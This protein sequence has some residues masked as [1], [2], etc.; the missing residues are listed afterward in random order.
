MVVEIYPAWHGTTN[1][2][3][4]CI[5]AHGFKYEKYKPGVKQ[6]RHPN[7]LGN[8]TYFFL[9]FAN[10]SGKTIASAYVQKYK[11]KELEE[12]AAKPE[13]IKAR[14][15]FDSSEKIFVLDETGLAILDEF[16][17]EFDDKLAPHL[18]DIKNDGAKKRASKL[19]QNQGLLIELLLDL[20]AEYN[21]NYDAVRA[22]TYTNIDFLPVIDGNNGT[23][24]CIRNKD[25]ITD[26]S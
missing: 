26:L 5:L 19:N 9:P 23:E 18:V 25:C 6:Q 13:L 8:G 24:I 22:E 4:N 14:L 2:R 16:K 17:K 7:D 3:K 15:K 1:V 21:N 11:S 12:K 20:A 10:D